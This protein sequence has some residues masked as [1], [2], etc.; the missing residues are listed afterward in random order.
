MHYQRLRDQNWCVWNSSWQGDGEDTRNGAQGAH[1]LAPHPDRPASRL[2]YYDLN[3]E[4]RRVLLTL[5]Y[6][7]CNS[8]I[9]LLCKMDWKYSPRVIPEIFS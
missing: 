2:G 8:F 4:Q 7:D 6:F 1:Y 3:S 9:Y 5:L